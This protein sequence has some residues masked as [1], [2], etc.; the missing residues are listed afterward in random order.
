MHGFNW[1]WAMKND[2]EAPWY[3]FC[4]SWR[5]F[6]LSFE[7]LL[8]KKISII[9]PFEKHHSLITYNLTCQTGY[10]HLLPWRT[11][12]NVSYYTMINLYTRC[13]EGYDSIWYSRCGAFASQRIILNIRGRTKNKSASPSLY[14]TFVLQALGNEMYILWCL[15]L[16]L[17]I[18]TMAY[19]LGFK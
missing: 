12:Q 10:N 8:F 4:Y 13:I 15:S 11:V 6:T 17:M 19:L 14:N 18:D 3:S 2:R 1:N 9:L 5:L 7:L 16:F